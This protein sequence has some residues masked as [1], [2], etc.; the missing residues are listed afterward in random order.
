MR[1]IGLSVAA[2]AAVLLCA[3]AVAEAGGAG[4][5]IQVRPGANAITKALARARNG[6]TLRIHGGNYRESFS[7]T[8]RVR[9]VGAQGKRPVIDG[10]C[11]VGI[12]IDVRVSGVSIDHVSIRG[13]AE[14]FG[15]PSIALNFAGVA[16][17]RAHDVLTKETC[18]DGK[19]GINVFDS[20]RVK[21]I[22]NI[23]SGYLD[24]G[25]YVGEI[26]S[27]G[28]GTLRVSGNRTF[29]NNRGFIIEN[30]SGGDVL[31]DSNI[32]NRNTI[33]G[34]GTPA[35]IFLHN[36]DGT[37][38]DDNTIR[39]NGDIGIHLDANSDGNVL[40]ANTV[41]DN[42]TNLFDEGQGNCGMNNQFGDAGNV[43]PSC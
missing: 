3:P 6:D 33:S 36:S 23:A 16:S 29:A 30:I 12:V 19:Y 8:K 39:E 2:G 7:V 24:S 38:L 37:R 28:G 34:E 35:G 20:E 43:L 26:S 13:A 25:I 1:R 5:T 40:T 18:G 11:K 10:R 22:D 17:G 14:G 21:V 27:T 4:K 42:P 15:L 31:L 41:T 9:I 32:A